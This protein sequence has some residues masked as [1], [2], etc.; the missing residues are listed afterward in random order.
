MT[1]IIRKAVR[2]LLLNDSNELLL[3]C[4][5]D[6]DIRTQEGIMNKRFWCTLGGAIDAG[7]SIEQAALRELYEEAGLAAED[8]DLGP[9]VWHSAVDLMLKGKLTR[10]DESFIVAR[11]KQNNVALLLPTEDEKEVVKKLRWFSLEDIKEC[12]D[13]IFPL[14]LADYLPDV[15]AGSYP[16]SPIDITLKHRAE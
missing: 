8:I 6:F 12:S 7:E 3:M 9:V 10:L 1:P 14:A 16:E 11:T 2:V 13:V 15:I 4:V 5:Q